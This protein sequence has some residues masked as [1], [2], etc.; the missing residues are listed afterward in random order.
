VSVKSL[1]AYHSPQSSA[2]SSVS[3]NAIEYQRILRMGG[4]HSLTD[5]R[6]LQNRLVTSSNSSAS[7][8]VLGP[9]YL[10]GK[11]VKWVGNKLLQG[12]VQIEVRRRRWMIGRFMTNLARVTPA[13]RCA[14]IVKKAHKMNQATE[15]LLE[16]SL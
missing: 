7:S 15:D 1:A 12:I 10:S 11:A 8:G 13:D 14:W 2:K 5:I 3:G 4:R 16:L 9:G 6:S